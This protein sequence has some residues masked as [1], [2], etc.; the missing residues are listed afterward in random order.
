MKNLYTVEGNVVRTQTLDS[1]PHLT[2]VDGAATSRVPKLSLVNRPARAAISVP[3]NIC[4]IGIACIIAV[5]CLI[6]G[7]A[8][9]SLKA[10][11]QEQAISSL[12]RASYTVAAGDTLWS[13]AE[14]LSIGNVPTSEAIRI[15]REW[16][17]LDSGLLHPGMELVVP[18]NR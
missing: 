16:N 14:D 13:I 5:T 7:G 11:A 8:A 10:R 2:V 1:H 4:T 3:T 17:A 9:A 15:M 18:I 6:A 12:A